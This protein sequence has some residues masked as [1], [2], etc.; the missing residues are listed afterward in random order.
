MAKQSSKLNSRPVYCPQLYGISKALHIHHNGQNYDFSVKVLGIVPI[1]FLNTYLRRKTFIVHRPTYF[2]GNQQ[3]LG[4]PSKKVA[5]GHNL[6][7]VSCLWEKKL[8]GFQ[9]GEITFTSAF[10]ALSFYRSQNVLCWSK[11]FKSAQK[12]DCI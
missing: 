7:F 10:Y 3:I 5:V 8:K 2:K 6:H 9:K 12:F 1:G 11:C 4:N